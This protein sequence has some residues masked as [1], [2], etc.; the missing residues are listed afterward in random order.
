[1]DP[2]SEK[3]SVIIYTRP[4]CHLCD[5]AKK[6][7]LAAGM[8]NEYTLAEVNIEEDRELLHLYRNDI[9]VITINGREAFRHRVA[10]TDFK[11][12]LS[13]HT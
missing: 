3:P 1:M 9:P 12:A 7:M 11:Q 5:E 4:G 2:I 10:T 8:Q 13:R 6:N